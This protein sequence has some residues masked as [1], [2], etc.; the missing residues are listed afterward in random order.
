MRWLVDSA[1]VFG[2][3]LFLYKRYVAFYGMAIFKWH[4]EKSLKQTDSETL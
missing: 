1:R 3:A 2:R 4:S